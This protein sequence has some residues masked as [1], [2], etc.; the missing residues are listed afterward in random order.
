MVPWERRH[1]VWTSD[2]KSRAARKSF[3]PI[4]NY[5]KGGLLVRPF[6][7]EAARV[8]CDIPC[9][10]P[11]REEGQLENPESEAGGT[12]PSGSGF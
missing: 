9:Q 7:L 2:L 10:K 1:P 6:C 3:A 5:F 8:D 12:P 11:D 4:T